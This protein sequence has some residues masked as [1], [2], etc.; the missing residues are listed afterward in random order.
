[1][2]NPV[3]TGAGYSI[4]FFA[5]FFYRRYFLLSEWLK[6]FSKKWITIAKKKRLDLI[7]R[8]AGK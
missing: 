6:T 7:L 5:K 2:L 3:L 8:L 4:I 1:M